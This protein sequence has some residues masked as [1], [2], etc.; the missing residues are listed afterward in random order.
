MLF[1]VTSKRESSRFNHQR[2]HRRTVSDW[3]CICA[4]PATFVRARHRMSEAVSKDNGED[5]SR[6]SIRLPRFSFE[7]EDRIHVRFMGV[8]HLPAA[9]LPDPL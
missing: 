7:M 3:E 8:P 9:Q 4:N 1:N 5:S 2:L 6:E